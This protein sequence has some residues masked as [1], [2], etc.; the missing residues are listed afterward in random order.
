MFIHVNLLQVVIDV[1]EDCIFIGKNAT[2]GKKIA[3]RSKSEA[4]GVLGSGDKVRPL[5][6]QSLTDDFY[7]V[8]D[9]IPCDNI[10]D[11]YEPGKYIYNNGEFELYEGIAPKDAEELTKDM[12]SLD[13]KV[14]EAVK[15]VFPEWDPNGYSYFAGEKVSYKYSFYRCIQ[16]HT[17][18]SDWAPDVAVSLWVEMSDPSEEWPEWKQP[19][20]AHDAY[21]KGDKVS[22]NS[23]HWTSS[24]DSNVWEPGVYGWDESELS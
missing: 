9:V 12:S 6:S 5:V 22:H 23:K 21:N 4:L 11:D 7:N 19:A 15:A 14:E 1:T 10:P 16:N 20:G 17:S 8:L 3:V 13:K 24:V 18:Q 2:T